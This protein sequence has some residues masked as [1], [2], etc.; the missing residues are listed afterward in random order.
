VKKVL[1][2]GLVAALVLPLRPAHAQTEPHR[3]SGEF[4]T[5]IL[6]Q[7][8]LASA[9]FA[10]DFS[11]FGGNVVERT[12][13]TL[14]V[15]TSGMFGVR[16]GYRVANNL[17]VMGSWQ[18]S[19][20]RYRIIFPAL[21]SDTGDFNLEGLILAGQD[22]VFTG[23][24]TRAESAVSTAVTDFYVG[25]L[26]YEFPTMNGWFYPYLPGGGGW[27][28]QR[29]SGDVIDITYQGPLPA[30]EQ[31]AEIAGINTVGLGGLSVFKIH[32]SEPLLSV[33]AGFRA[34]IGRKWGFLFE[35][36]DL[37]RF[38]ADLSSINSSAT[39]FPPDPD[40]GRVW[41]TEF[42]GTEGVIHN[43]SIAVSVNYSLW[44]YGAP[45]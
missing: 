10:A 38:Q 31:F 35:I 11:G 21:A 37:V 18:H 16:T 40:T 15:V 14:D 25:A 43:L 22:F 42:T 36:Q 30:F 17:Y 6:A 33:G 23:T 19:E 44:P 1:F 7:G 5:G 2:L 27:F 29:S 20:G 4:L 12:G 34:S 13:G 41:A 28:T 45:R 9:R 26:R 39:P 32:S 3:W 8:D 24:E